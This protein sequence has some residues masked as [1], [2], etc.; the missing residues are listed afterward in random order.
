MCYLDFNRNGW[1]GVVE[2]FCHLYRKEAVIVHRYGN[3]AIR[4]K[5]RVL[6]GICNY[7]M[8]GMIAWNT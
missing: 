6:A 7:G 2:N 8:P 1:M 3:M 4:V 5:F